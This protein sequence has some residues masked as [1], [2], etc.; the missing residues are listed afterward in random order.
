MEETDETKYTPSLTK[1]AELIV[2][3]DETCEKKLQVVAKNDLAVN[4]YSMINI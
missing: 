1:D 3:Y 2:Q 4:L